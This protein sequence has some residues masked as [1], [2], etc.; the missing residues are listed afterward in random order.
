MGA[1]APPATAL[2]LKASDMPFTGL[3]RCEKCGSQV[4]VSTKTKPSGKSY[5]YYHCSN[6]RG[7][8]PRAG[9]REDRLEMQ[10]DAL[11]ERI[12]IDDDFYAWAIEDIE[13]S[14]QAVR[15]VQ[16]DA[17]SQRRRALEEIGK[18]LD[19][20]VGMR[21]RELLTDEEY[22]TR[23][24]L[25]LKDR[26]HLQQEVELGDQGAD[27]VRE[28]C[29][30]AAE[31][32]RNARNWLLYGDATIKRIV[33]QHL[34]SNWVLK[35]KELLPELHPLMTGV[36]L[37]YP[38]LLAEKERIELHFLALRANKKRLLP[39]FVQLGAAYGT[40]IELWLQTL[41]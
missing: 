32:M 22:T 27:L 37:E 24:M 9:V 23:R 15:A 11:L 14:S 7:G 16:D 12:S 3:I 26:E 39:L 31:Y 13:R 41:D 25:L 38:S 17:Q 36:F 18:Q 19:A 29:L 6:S 5:T 35:G 40:K 2:R 28:T 1:E 10:I 33:A 8:C 30:N 4:T 34:V 21:M 20:L